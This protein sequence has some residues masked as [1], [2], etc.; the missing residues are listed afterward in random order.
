MRKRWVLVGMV[1]LLLPWLTVGCGIAEEEYAAVVS[2]LNKAEQEL[3]AVKTE[4][5]ASQAK[6]SGLTASLEESE[7]E[8][9]A[10]KAKNS[11]LTS[12]LEKNQTELEAAQAKVSELTASLEESESELTT[13]KSEYS[14]FKSEAK[15][16][17]LLLDSALALNNAILGINAGVILNDMDTVYKEC[18]N[19]SSELFQLKDKRIAEFNALWEEAFIET[20]QQ[21]ALYPAPFER[22]MALHASRI[23]DKTTWLREH[24]NK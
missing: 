4:L 22:F 13:T 23:S 1:F 11:E 18:L 3:Q 6:V 14:S 8:L 10:T 15:R 5:E 20:P 2:D 19:V 9:K 21:W 12:S 16:L 17:F 24:L 7:T